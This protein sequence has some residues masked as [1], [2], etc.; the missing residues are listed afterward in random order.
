MKEER[1]PSYV[2]NPPPIFFW[3]MDEFI[4]VA[5]VFAVVGIFMKS[6]FIAIILMWASGK[7]F[8]MIKNATHKGALFHLL[9]WY[10]LTKVTS[11]F[12]NGLAR[13]FGG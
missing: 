7:V 4:V 8:G 9:Y 6:F 10:G 1:L 13:E 3:E 5:I 2:D 11:K 12:D